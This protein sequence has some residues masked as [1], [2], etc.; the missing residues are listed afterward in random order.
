MVT[1]GMFLVAALEDMIKEAHEAES[2]PRILT[3]SLVF[4]FSL[5]AIVSQALG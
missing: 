1:A 4:G 2:G 3:L 5:F